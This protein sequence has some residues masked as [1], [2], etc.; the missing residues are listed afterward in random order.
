MPT[1]GAVVATSWTTPDFFSRSETVERSETN[2]QLLEQ[3][4]RRGAS[5]ILI[6]Q[7]EGWGPRLG[8]GRAA[9]Q[10][11]V[12]DGDCPG[13]LPTCLLNE[14]C[15]SLPDR[16]RALERMRTSATPS[17]VEDF[18]RRVRIVYEISNCTK[19]STDTVSMELGEPATNTSCTGGEWGC[20]DQVCRWR[21]R[22][23]PRTACPRNSLT[24]S[25]SAAA[26]PLRCRW[27][28]PAR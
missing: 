19:T 27:Q 3:N 28:E 16:D 7:R 5:N 10:Y 2:W 20:P 14:N 13:A 11:E 8:P 26:T 22:G 24:C 9:C 18:T 6:C 17:N 23:F 1:V 25:A 12:P 15:T 4:N 21:S